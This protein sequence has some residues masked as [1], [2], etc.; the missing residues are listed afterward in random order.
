[1]LLSEIRT[2]LSSFIN[3]NKLTTTSNTFEPNNPNSYDFYIAMALDYLER[4][5]PY[6]SKL[7]LATG[8]LV[9]NQ[10]KVV[11][12]PHHYIHR[13]TVANIED[14]DNIQ[15]SDLFYLP[16]DVFL[17]ESKV[18]L[19]SLDSS[20][21]NPSIGTPIYWT[22]LNNSFSNELAGFETKRTILIYPSPESSNVFNIE[23]IASLATISSISTDILE[24]PGTIL[25]WQNKFSSSKGNHPI[26]N[27]YPYTL[28]HTVQMM[29]NKTRGN[30]AGYAEFKKM[31]EDDIMTIN[32]QL[33]EFEL[34]TTYKYEKV[35][36]A[37][38]V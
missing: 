33:V 28:I 29:Y 6:I 5:L 9:A 3:N 11:L 32:Q 18:N 12:Q 8:I 36:G 22:Y 27:L 34:A 2:V 25:D 4:E 19:L 31:L 20:S 35:K 16:L 7:Y 13:I 1:M 15:R 30:I 17:K 14:K 38:P 26:S 23:I 37:L 10:I 24:N 21:S